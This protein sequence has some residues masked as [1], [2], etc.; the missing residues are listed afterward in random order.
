M[1][2]QEAIETPR[3]H[4]QWWPD[5]IFYETRGLSADTQAA[6]QTRGY[7]LQKQTP[8]SGVAAIMKGLPSLNAQ[9]FESSG[10]DAMLS[11]KVRAGY[12]YGSSGARR[13]VGA[14]KEF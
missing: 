8:W 2:L 9:E 5:R 14:A 11:G 12:I 4:H 13:P 7:S 6:L 10:N 1:T 3:I